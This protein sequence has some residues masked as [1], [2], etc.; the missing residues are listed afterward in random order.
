MGHGSHPPAKVSLSKSSHC[1]PLQG[2]GGSGCSSSNGFGFTTVLLLGSPRIFRMEPKVQAKV[3]K[4]E[5]SHQVFLTIMLHPS[6]HRADGPQH[7]ITNIDCC[8][9]EVFCNHNKTLL[10]WQRAAFRHAL[11]LHSCQTSRLRCRRKH[12][13]SRVEPTAEKANFRV[14]CFRFCFAF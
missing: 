2:P 7:I 12:R 13:Q 5:A 6:E 8:C 1:P 9:K 14:F 3:V 10:Y 4:P 11:L